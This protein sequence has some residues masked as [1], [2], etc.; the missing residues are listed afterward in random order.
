MHVSPSFARCCVVAKMGILRAEDARRSFWVVASTEGKLWMA[1]RNLSWRSQMLVVLVF[2]CEGGLE[3][4]DATRGL[5]S[6]ERCE[7]SS[8]MRYR[9]EGRT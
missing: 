7:R 9:Y 4:M 8:W 2:G 5:G 3:G 1:G 6:L